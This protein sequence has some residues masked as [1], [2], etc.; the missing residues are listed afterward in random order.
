MKK[1]KFTFAITIESVTQGETLEE[2]EEK[3]WEDIAFKLSNEKYDE[4]GIMEV[5]EID[6]EGNLHGPHSDSW[7]NMEE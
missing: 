6:E 1:Y 4:A 2:A 5:Q 3:A 7:V